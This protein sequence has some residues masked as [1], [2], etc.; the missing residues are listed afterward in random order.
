MS[1]YSPALRLVC[2][3]GVGSTVR[4][5]TPIRHFL[6]RWHQCSHFDPA[7]YTDEDPAIYASTH[8]MRIV[9]VGCGFL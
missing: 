9:Q 3:L 8:C 2:S 1:D 6:L 7:I 4:L 5:E